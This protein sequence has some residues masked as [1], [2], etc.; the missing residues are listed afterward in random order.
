MHPRKADKAAGRRPRGRDERGVV[1]LA[2]T[3]ILFFAALIIAVSVQSA[4]LGELLSGA[5]DSAGERAFQAAD[6]CANEALLRLARDSAYAGGSLSV[7][8]GTCTI[9]VTGGGSA[10]TIDVSGTVASAT[11]RATLSVTVTGGVVTVD[12]WAEVTN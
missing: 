2:T 1:T 5:T 3:V 6:S 7:G 4:G 12:D 9:T 11:R 8:A 10:R